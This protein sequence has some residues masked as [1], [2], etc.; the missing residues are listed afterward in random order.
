MH[1]SKLINA[2]VVFVVPDVKKTTN[3]YREVLG[4]RA[5]EHFEAEEQF[6]AL[7]RDDVE[8]VVVQSKHGDVK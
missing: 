1:P 8:I 7:Y 5:V 3:Y 4:F 2:V 6:A